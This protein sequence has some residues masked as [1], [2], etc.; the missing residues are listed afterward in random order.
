MEVHRGLGVSKHLE[1]IAT[2]ILQVTDDIGRRLIVIAT[3]I[4]F[5]RQRLMKPLEVTGIPT[6]TRTV[7]DF[8]ESKELL[9]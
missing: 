4:V 7:L 3:E 9:E 2:G 8:L 5:V 1:S 6:M